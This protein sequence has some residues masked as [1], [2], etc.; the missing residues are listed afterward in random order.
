MLDVFDRRPQTL[1][2]RKAPAVVMLD[3]FL[4]N[5]NF[6]AISIETYAEKA[7]NYTAGALFVSAPPNGNILEKL[8]SWWDEASNKSAA[9][10]RA[11]L[12]DASP[13]SAE[14]LPPT[15]AAQRLSLHET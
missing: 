5:D 14:T 11:E 8:R 15:D 1:S 13:G 10:S 9:I 2:V 4:L 3:I 12:S 6:G 7:H